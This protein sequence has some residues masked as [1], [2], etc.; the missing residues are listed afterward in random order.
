MAR[1]LARNLLH[2]TQW[3][4]HLYQPTIQQQTQSE[5][6]VYQDAVFRDAALVNILKQKDL[7][8]D[9]YKSIKLKH[10]V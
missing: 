9:I 3:T 1:C 4:E 7:Y 6:L 8:G 2:N 10:Y 5:R